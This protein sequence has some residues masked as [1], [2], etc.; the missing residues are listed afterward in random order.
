MNYKLTIKIDDH[1]ETFENFSGLYSGEASKE[2]Y[3]K[4]VKASPSAEVE[5]WMG[6][7]TPLV[8]R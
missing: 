6:C 5:L 7:I 3:R 4:A 8:S 2:A 1:T